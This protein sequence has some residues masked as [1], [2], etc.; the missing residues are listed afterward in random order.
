M[1]IKFYISYLFNNPVPPPPLTLHQLEFFSLNARPPEWRRLELLVNGLRTPYIICDHPLQLPTN[2]LGWNLYHHPI[3]LPHLGTFS[4]SNP[5]NILYANTISTPDVPQFLSPFPHHFQYFLKTPLRI[6]FLLPADA[7]ISIPKHS[8]TY[9]LRCIATFQ[10]FSRRFSLIVIDNLLSRLL[11]PF[12]PKSINT[13]LSQFPSSLF[14]LR[15]QCIS[16]FRRSI[17]EPF[18]LH[19]PPNHN[20]YHLPEYS[21]LLP[22]G[23]PPTSHDPTLLLLGFNPSTPS[24]FDP[25]SS[26]LGLLRNLFRTHSFSYTKIKN[27]LR[28]GVT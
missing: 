5:V 17:A 27:T 11:D 25:S 23:F 1:V 20:L 9:E 7:T 24:Q 22:S 16:S 6:A 19:L 8:P 12:I 13:W 4:T 26:S 2:A 21:Y 28:Q 10:R 15:D 3:S 14:H 18:I